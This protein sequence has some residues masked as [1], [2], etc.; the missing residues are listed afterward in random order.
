MEESLRGWCMVAAAIA[1]AA[2]LAFGMTA[3]GISRRTLRE[4]GE[5]VLLQRSV[6]IVGEDGEE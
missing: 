4:A 6:V 5:R 1:F 3:A 2:A